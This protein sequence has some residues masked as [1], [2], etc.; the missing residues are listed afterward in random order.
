[1]DGRILPVP[2]TTLSLVP[3]TRKRWRLIGMVRRSQGLFVEVI[4]LRLVAPTLLPG[5][6]PASVPGCGP[7]TFI[8]S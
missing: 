7:E 1:V 2:Y 5:S 6:P 3:W 8:C 4:V